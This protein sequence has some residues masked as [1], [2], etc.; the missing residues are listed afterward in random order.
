VKPAFI[1]AV[2]PL[3]KG[4]LSAAQRNGLETLLA[5][6]EGLPIRHRAYILAT[7]YHETARTMQPVRETLAETDAEMVGRLERAWQRGQLKWV[8]TPYWRFDADGKTWAGRGYVQLT[9]VE[10]Y[11]RAGAKLGVDLVADPNR[12]LNPDLA[13]RILV[14]GMREGWFT[15]AK[16]ADQ[17]YREMRRIVN[18]TDR[19]DLIAE[20]AEAFEAAL[21]TIKSVE[22]APVS[23][24]LA[25]LLAALVAFIASIFRRKT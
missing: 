3:F 11:A 13:A 1:E 7:A 20:H 6:T 18:G 2:A 8:R 10:N 19:A 12:A 14:R 16:L 15:G 24:P 22:P 23:S 9:H 25:G 17:S 4:Y 5:A 21:A